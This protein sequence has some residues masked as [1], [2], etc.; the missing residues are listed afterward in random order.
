MALIINLTF[1]FALAFL[2]ESFTE[3]L[4]GTPMDHVAA[5]QRF[6]WLLMYLA[7]V[8]GVGLA[9]YYR[10]DLIGM[11]PAVVDPAREATATPVGMALTGLGLGR[12][13][14]W[15]HDFVM[16]FIVKPTDVAK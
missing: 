6:K 12:G 10:L 1:A 14:N 11:I 3:Y 5:I 13:A 8:A 15:L 7:A 4:A 2:V 16:G 9:F